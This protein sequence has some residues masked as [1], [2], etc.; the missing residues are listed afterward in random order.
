MLIGEFSRET[1]LSLDTVRFYVRKGLIT[2]QTGTKGGRQPWQIFRAQDV[3]TAR[4][5]RTAQSLGLSLRE[6]DELS[7]ALHDD[8]SSERE[9]AVLDQQIVRLESKAGEIAQ[10]LGFLRAKREWIAS[11]KAGRMPTLSA[12]RKA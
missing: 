5:I 4:L 11:G 7:K 12:F 1:G 2:P 6:I 10:V 9:R 3:A 8:S